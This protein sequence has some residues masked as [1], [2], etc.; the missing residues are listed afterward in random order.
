MKKFLRVV[1]GTVFAISFAGFAITAP[2]ALVKSGRPGMALAVSVV[3]LMAGFAAWKLFASNFSRNLGLLTMVLFTS[4]GICIAAMHDV[5]PQ[6]W[7]GSFAV[8]LMAFSLIWLL[9]M[10]VTLQIEKNRKM[11]AQRNRP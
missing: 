4:I 9:S 6:G 11:R 7:H 8:F 10:L 5:Q 3:W 2:V 1:A